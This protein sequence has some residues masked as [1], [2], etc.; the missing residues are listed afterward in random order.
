MSLLA[1]KKGD[2]K[3]QTMN[4]M[5]F[6][7]RADDEAIRKARAIKEAAKTLSDLAETL[8]NELIASLHEGGHDRGKNGG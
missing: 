7:I 6:T 1:Y 2:G 8:E 5:Y 3:M 4:D